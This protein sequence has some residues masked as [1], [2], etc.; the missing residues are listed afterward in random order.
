MQAGLIQFFVRYK[1]LLICLIVS[2]ILRLILIGELVYP[3]DLYG[4]FKP[5]AMH[6]A[7]EGLSNFYQAVEYEH[8]P[9]YIPILWLQG[10]LTDWLKTFLQISEEQLFLIIFKIPVILA[11][12][13]GGVYAYLLVN[14]LTRKRHLAL[15]S[16]ILY[17]FNP[18]FLYNTMY[19]AQIDGIL[20][21]GIIASAYY[22]V[23]KRLDLSILAG[24]LVASVKPQA[25]FI[26]A[27]IILAA[28]FSLCGDPKLRSD[29]KALLS[30]L[31]G[32][33]LLPGLAVFSLNYLILIPI[34]GGNLF[35]LWE[36]MLA[37]LHRYPYASVNGANFW[38]LV[39][40][41]WQIDSEFMLW[42]ISSNL[43][44]VFTVLGLLIGGGLSIAN[45]R[46]RHQIV[47][48]LAVCLQLAAYFATRQHE[49]YLEY[50]IALL[51]A[52]ALIHRSYPAWIALLLYTTGAFLNQSLVA[53][54][55]SWLPQIPG[56]D[57]S[58]AAICLGGGIFFT[59][60]DFIPWQR[61]ARKILAPYQ[62]S[63]LVSF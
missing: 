40:G 4:A 18:S 56:V 19:W 20:C 3:A 60:I 14:K 1:Y 8:P 47:L 9:G 62:R 38:L 58:L 17:L 48:I 52:W 28:F 33:I 30:R 23:I 2:F 27:L 50:P 44:S 32:Q 46:Y 29:H 5:W 34:N 22:M 26:L 31:F 59:L 45:S 55:P 49:R 15:W 39:G 36:A 42:S 57:M 16:V 54:Y 21:L 10:S 35:E 11:D 37:S 51:I 41:N 13:A 53:E 7:R 6:A 43:L 61:Y 24:C 12:L 63:E 25:I